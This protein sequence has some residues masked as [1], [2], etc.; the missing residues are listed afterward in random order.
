M[1]SESQQVQPAGFWELRTGW[2]RLKHSLLLEPL[3]GGSRWAAAFGSLLLFSFVLQVFTGVL[4]T[5]NYAPSAHTA[6]P[7]VKYIQDEVPL[8]WLIRGAHHW[9]SSLMVIL[10]L[11]HLV[12][13][14]VWGATRSRAN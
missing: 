8:G 1:S 13:V 14:F 5:M 6:W 7:S 11:V 12:Q 10:L 2:S 3:L 9:G 4:L